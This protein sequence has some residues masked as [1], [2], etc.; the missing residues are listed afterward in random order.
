MKKWIIHSILILAVITWLFLTGTGIYSLTHDS[1]FATQDMVL[2]IVGA[3]LLLVLVLFRILPKRF[4]NWYADTAGGIS[5][6]CMALILVMFIILILNQAQSPEWK[7]PYFITLLISLLVGSAHVW[8][9]DR[10]IKQK[11]N[12]QEQMQP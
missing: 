5:I 7:Q 6:L 12:T 3:Y 4:M 2:I 1:L 11:E 8:L 9:P 10:Y